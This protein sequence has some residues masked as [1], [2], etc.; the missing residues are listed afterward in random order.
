LFVRKGKGGVLPR[1]EVALASALRL[2]HDDP[3]VAG[4]LLVVLW[5]N[6]DVNRDEL[7]R[8]AL[9]RGEGQTPGF[10]LELTDGLDGA[11]ERNWIRSEGLEVRAPGRDR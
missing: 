11:D 6:R 9:R 8:L 10:L 4:N 7:T 1:L 5:K 3:A 2:A